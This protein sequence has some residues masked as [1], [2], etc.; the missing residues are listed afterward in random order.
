[1]SLKKRWKANWDL[2][3]FTFDE[4]FEIIS[5]VIRKQLTHLEKDSILLEHD[6]ITT[7]EADSVDVVTMLLALEEIFK[8]AS[9]A[10]GTAVPTDKL[11]Q[12]HLVEDL[13]DVIY[14]LLAEMESKTP[15]G[16]KIHADL[17]ALENQGASFGD[18]YQPQ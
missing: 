8:D 11:G 15:S 3:S 1:M 5:K 17:K 6:F 10:T 14:E 9:D 13:F 16:K 12:I 7:Y 18:M 2:K 4:L